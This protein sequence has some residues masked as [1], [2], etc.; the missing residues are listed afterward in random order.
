MVFSG[1]LR[2]IDLFCGCGGISV[3]LQQAGFEIVAGIDVEKKYIAS[4]EHNFPDAKALLT[5]ITAVS[6]NDFMVEVGISPG[7][8]DLL[9]GDLPVKVSRRMYPVATVFWKTQKIC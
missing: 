6:P 7:E 3:G 1:K 4:F 9:A 2:A 8:L 5:D